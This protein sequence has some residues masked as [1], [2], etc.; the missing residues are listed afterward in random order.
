MDRNA[1]RSLITALKGEVLE[2]LRSV[3][4]LDDPDLWQEVAAKIND[5]LLVYR[6][7]GRVITDE[8]ITF[9]F[10]D[11]VTRDIDHMAAAHA[12]SAVWPDMDNDEELSS[13]HEWLEKWVEKE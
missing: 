12:A 8:P 10:S 9:T 5:V 3:D 6:H 13:F 1:K 4:L 7:E 11:G 2:Y